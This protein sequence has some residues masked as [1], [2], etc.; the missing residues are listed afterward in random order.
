[1]HG[2]SLAR[3]TSPTSTPSR[4]SRR[5]SRSN[6]GRSSRN[7]RST[8][9]TVTEIYDYLRLLF[10]RIGVPHCPNDGQEINAQSVDRVV[11]AIRA[12]AQGER[13]ELIAPVVRGKKG[14]HRDVMEK[15]R[16]EGYR[17]FVI[18]GVEVQLPGTEVKLEKNKKHTIEVVVDTLEA[19]PSESAR[20]AESVE[21]ARG[22]GDGLVILRRP[23]GERR[24]FSSRRACPE[25]G[26]S[27]E[28]LTPRMFSFNNPFGACPDARSGGD[29]ACRPESHPPGQTYSRSRRPSRSGG[30]RRSVKRWN[31]SG[32]VPVRPRDSR[33]STLGEG[34]EGA[35]LRERQARAS[36]AIGE[37][38]GGAAAG[39]GRG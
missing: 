32:D 34:L 33:P 23:K 28:E 20:L 16:K 5:R 15:L 4:G 39:C 10:A 18:D 14:E 6:S 38:T 26:F 1:M 22:L 11:E 29:P 8:V 2:S 25:C 7:P 37:S 21:L 27:I 19:T 13:I 24:T 9:G 36:P 31:G 3:W 12:S 35:L 17:R 30:L